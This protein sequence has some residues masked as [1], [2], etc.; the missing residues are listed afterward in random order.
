[1]LAFPV[2]DIYCLLGRREFT[3]LFLIQILDTSGDMF[4]DKEI[5]A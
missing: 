5:D 1:M 4:L 3:I 2:T